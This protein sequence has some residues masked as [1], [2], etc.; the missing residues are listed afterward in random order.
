MVLLR[1][2]LTFS[3]A[4]GHITLLDRRLEV[5]WLIP[6]RLSLLLAV[7]SVRLVLLLLSAR[8]VSLRFASLCPQ[9]RPIFRL[10]V[11]GIFL[12]WVFA[13][14]IRRVGL[15]VCVQW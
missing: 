12:R 2:V 8:G 5:E 4:Q 6:V 3:C 9:V 14:C 13:F 11:S 10:G 15:Q 7:V 1:L